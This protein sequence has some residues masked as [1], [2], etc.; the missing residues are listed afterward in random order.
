[1]DANAR[2]YLWDAI[3][4]L[5]KD[6]V[7]LLTT[8]DMNEADYLGDRIAIMNEGQLITVGTSIFLK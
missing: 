1:M 7:I 3:K 4:N 8:H 2:R 6:R 5:K